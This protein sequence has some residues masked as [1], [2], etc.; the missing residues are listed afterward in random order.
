MAYPVI[1]NSSGIIA[2]EK[3]ALRAVKQWTFTP[4]TENGKPIQQCHNKVQLDFTLEQSAQGARRRF[5]HQY[6][7]AEQL[8]KEQQWQQARESIAA[9]ADSPTWNLYES[10]WLKFL[11]SRLYKGLNQPEKQSV[12]LKSLY[13]SAEQYL[14]EGHYLYVLKELF[15]YNVKHNRPGAALRVY[16]KLQHKDK[17][18]KI[19]PHFKPYAEQVKALL[20]GE[21]P[22]VT[23]AKIGERGYWY[24][25][26]NRSSF[27]LVN[28]QQPLDKL[29]IRCKNKRSTY[30][31][32][33]DK[34]WNIPQKWGQ[35]SVFVYGEQAS[36]FEFVELAN[37]VSEPDH[38]DRSNSD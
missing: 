16:K 34:T 19:V 30:K 4:A 27:S 24:T 29:D 38:H 18:E 9:M 6:K 37:K 1:E 20:D 22:I 10:A 21:Q 33:A 25:R 14:P 15:I 5:I 3:A 35:C 36:E 12:Y 8:L 17:Q 23:N 28:M 32:E 31:I 26:L 11:Q 2:F 7:Q 13:S